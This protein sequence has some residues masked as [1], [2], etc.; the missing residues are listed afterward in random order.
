MFLVLP[1]CQVFPVLPGCQVFPVLPGC[2]VFLVLPGCQMFPV[3]PGC[4]VFPEEGVQDQPVLDCT[5]KGV[6]IDQG[7]N[8]LFSNI[9]VCSHCSVY[10]TVV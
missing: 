5:F 8:T 4:Q 9:A 7:M 3:L 6:L 2:Q 10:N 1:G